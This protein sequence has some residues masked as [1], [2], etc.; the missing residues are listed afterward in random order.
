MKLHGLLIGACLCPAS[1]GRKQNEHG[2][3]QNT[4]SH[5]VACS[6]SGYGCFLGSLIGGIQGGEQ[7]PGKMQI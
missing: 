7:S 6:L 4:H 2:C 3:L 5:R 1:L